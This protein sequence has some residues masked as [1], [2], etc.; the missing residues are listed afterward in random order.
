MYVLAFNSNLIALNDNNG[1]TLP[2]AMKLLSH[3]QTSSH[4]YLCPFLDAVCFAL[5]TGL[6]VGGFVVGLKVGVTVGLKV[7]G[8]VFG[9]KVGTLVGLLVGGRVASVTCAK[10]GEVGEAVGL[11]VEVGE[12]CALLIS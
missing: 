9:F 11:L 5:L 8:F 10:G 4:H 3:K 12:G 2:K 1:C 6:F 7:G